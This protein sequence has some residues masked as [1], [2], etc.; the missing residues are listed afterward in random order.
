MFKFWTSICQNMGRQLPI[1]PTRHFNPR[2]LVQLYIFLFMNWWIMLSQASSIDIGSSTNFTFEWLLSI[3][4]CIYM[5]IRKFLYRFSI[6]IITFDWLV[7]FIDWSNLSVQMMSSCKIGI[8]SVTFEC[9]LPLMNCCNMF[10]QILFS[11]KISI[12]SVTFEC[13]LFYGLK[14]YIQIRYLCKFSIF[15]FFPYELHQYVLST[16]FLS[17]AFITFSTLIPFHL[18]N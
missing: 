9:L 7:S 15:V 13:L 2:H 1:L 14:Q 12:T 3:M 16:L 11:S 10:V 8:T 17:K 4:N 6:T 18:M 5:F